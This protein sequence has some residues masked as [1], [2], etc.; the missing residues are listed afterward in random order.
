M[1]VLVVIFMLTLSIADL[2]FSSS[3][4]GIVEGI[5]L[6]AIFMV[7]GVSL[8]WWLNNNTTARSLDLA[9]LAFAIA[10]AIGIVLYH[11]NPEISAVRMLGIVLTFIYVC[12]IAFPNYAFLM[13][14][15]VLLMLSGETYNVVSSGREEL[16]S[17][18]LIMLLIALFAECIGILSSAYHH[19]ARYQTY[20]AMKQVKLLSGL[21]PICS[22][23][24]KIR[25]DQGYYQK[26]E[27]YITE[28]SEAHFTHG[29]CPDCASD[30]YAEI[31]EYKNSE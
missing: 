10:I 25:D 4:E 26:I 17:Y 22:S 15:P 27:T 12:H 23:C 16:Q 5:A 14:F 8:L 30:M 2:L 18:Q 19:Q 24:K 9:S 21:L 29:I 20:N 1:I 3:Q 13:V 7:M 28:H 6:R 11:N 31:E